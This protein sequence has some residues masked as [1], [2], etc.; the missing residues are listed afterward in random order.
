MKILSLPLLITVGCRNLVRTRSSVVNENWRSLKSLL[1]AYLYYYIL[2]NIHV[3][4]ILLDTGFPQVVPVHNQPTPQTIKS[5]EQVATIRKN[6]KG[7]EIFK[8]LKLLV[9]FERLKTKITEEAPRECL[10]WRLSISPKGQPVSKVNLKMVS[11]WLLANFAPWIGTS[12]FAA[13][14][15]QLGRI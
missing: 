8:I 4:I 9:I 13:G 3:M 1:N 7:I 12:M 10:V 6:I 2:T 5:G 11:S 14:I 15:W